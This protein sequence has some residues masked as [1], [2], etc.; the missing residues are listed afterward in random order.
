MKMATTAIQSAFLPTLTQ[1]GHKREYRN[2]TGGP[3]VSMKPTN[4]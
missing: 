1:G 2:P 4:Q 3:E